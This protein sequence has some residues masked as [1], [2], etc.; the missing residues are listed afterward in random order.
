MR[1]LTL[2]ALTLAILIGVVYVAKKQPGPQKHQ[3]IVQNPWPK[4]KEE[5]P[6]QPPQPKPE[7]TFEQAIGEITE[8]DLLK[9]MNYLCSQENEGRMSGKAGNKTCAV[10]VEQ[11]FTAA[12]LNVMRQKFPISRANPGPKNENGDDFSENIIA[13]IDGNDP[14]LKNE[15]MVVG[16]HMDHIGYGPQWSSARGQGL[17]I[18]P[19]A[20]DNA[21]GTTALIEIA[22]A[23]AKC[24][25]QVK[26]TTIFMAFSGEEMGLV[27]SR[28]YCNNPVFPKNG[29]S[30]SKHIF[31]LNMDMIGY[32]NKGRL[33]ADWGDA[34]KVT[35][36][37]KGIMNDLSGKYTFARSI[38]SSGSGGSDHASFAA[39]N[40][41]VCILHTGQHPQ[42]HTPQD[43]V[44]RINMPGM[45]QVTKYATELA[46]RIGHAPRFAS[47]YGGELKKSEFDHDSI[48][49]GGTK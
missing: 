14:A 17:K 15:I 2:L 5:K 1:K 44:D 46:W 18:H 27:G 25:S 40:V 20:D 47:Y 21:S 3:P 6:P 11:Q 45:T 10:Y 34:E 30:M 41:P 26:R 39:K 33:M 43:T 13:W 9:H 28:Y 49:F 4:Q 8:A 22:R 37:L 48:Q 35:P 29:P 19:G 23:H 38:T 31:M 42:Y 16:A 36:D 24:K 32:L 7:I 12:G